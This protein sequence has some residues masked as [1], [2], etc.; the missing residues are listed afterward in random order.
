MVNSMTVPDYRLDP[1]TPVDYPDCPL[2]GTSLYDYLVVDI[3][4]DVVGCSECTK[5]ITADEFLERDEE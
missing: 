3:C 5:H 1:P 4:G 2:C